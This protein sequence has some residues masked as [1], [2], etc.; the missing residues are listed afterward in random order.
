[1]QEFRTMA[2]KVNL[3]EATSDKVSNNADDDDFDNVIENLKRT[4]NARVVICFCEG[5]TVR[6]LLEAS[7]RK[8]AMG[9]FLFIGR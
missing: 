5:M 9:H 1:M 4:E 2:R 8:N 7:K 6:R 3:C